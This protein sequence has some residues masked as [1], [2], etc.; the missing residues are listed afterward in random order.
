MGCVG[1]GL[2]A[3]LGCVGCGLCEFGPPSA[4]SLLCYTLCSFAVL[5][6]GPC[7]PF[8]CPCAPEQMNKPSPPPPLPS[9]SSETPLTR[10]TRARTLRARITGTTRCA[11]RVPMPSTRRA[12]RMPSLKSGAPPLS[13][14]ASSDAPAGPEGGPRPRVLPLRRG[15][16]QLQRKRVRRPRQ[17]RGS[18]R[19]SVAAYEG[20]R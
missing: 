14:P 15:L 4:P 8:M 18:R 9:L 11:L 13:R 10:S 20:Q 7:V 2:W 19:G 1:C 17:R 6:A 16:L 5:P 3:V 12:R